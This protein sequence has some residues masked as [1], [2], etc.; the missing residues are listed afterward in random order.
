MQ[1]DETFW[2]L[3]TFLWDT[4][5]HNN[6]CF[7]WYPCPFEHLRG[8]NA[9]QECV[10]YLQLISKIVWRTWQQCHTHLGYNVG[11]RLMRSF[12]ILGNGLSMNPITHREH[13]IQSGYVSLHLTTSYIII[14]THQLLRNHAWCLPLSIQMWQYPEELTRNQL[15]HSSLMTSNSRTPTFLNDTCRWWVFSLGICPP[16]CPLQCVFFEFSLQTWV[17]VQDQ[18]AVQHQTK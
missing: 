8:P 18:Q 14:M 2:T 16:V 17:P 1:M 10:H 3:I 15:T 7:H 13:N 4:C 5:W 11:N 9:L 12:W 6:P